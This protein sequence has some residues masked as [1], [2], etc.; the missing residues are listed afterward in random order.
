[1]RLRLT[2][3]FLL[4]GVLGIRDAG[5]YTWSKCGATSTKIRWSTATISLR[6][7][8]V[9]F[10]SGSAY[11]AALGVVASRWNG[12]ASKVLYSMTYDDPTVGLHNGQSEI[13]WCAGCS[14]LN[15]SPAY[16]Y[17]W[18][19]SSC[20]IVEADQIYDNQV[21]YTSGTAKSTLISYGGSYRPFRTTAMHEFGHAQG[22]GHTATLYNIMGQDWTHIHANGG[23]A[24]AYP[25]EDAVNGSIATYGATSGVQDLGVAQW[26]RT[27]AS[28]A[29][30]VHSRTRLMNTSNVELSKVAGRPEPTYFV[31]KGQTVRF[32]ITLENMGATVSLSPALGMYISTDD[33][34]S[35]GDR[36]IG[37]FSSTLGRDTPFTTT[38]TVTIPGDL[39]SGQYYWIGIIV[40][41]NNKVAETYETNNQTY[42]GIRVN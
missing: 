24:T 31:S 34:I 30:S 35:T 36:F 16:T 13:W 27:G 1:M 10:P 3:A 7:S 17:W 40:D 38:L 42:I 15:G 22:L 21:A 26:R 8:Q 29:Y 11:R 41:Y 2:A 37:S 28:G 9:G 32:E 6:A 14:Q 18:W 19:N 33:Q 12:T 25:G 39:I 23:T 20:K 5:A 4:L